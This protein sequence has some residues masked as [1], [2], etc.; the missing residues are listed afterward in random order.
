MGDPDKPC[1]FL[2]GFGFTISHDE[3]D[4]IKT[5]VEPALNSAV[6]RAAAQAGVAYIDIQAATRGHELCSDTDDRWINGIV[7]GADVNVQSL[8]P[9]PERT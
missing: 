7:L 6:S 2:G 4:W 9:Q 1:G 5:V 8:P 3:L